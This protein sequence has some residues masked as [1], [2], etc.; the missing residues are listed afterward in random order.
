MK[1]FPV[2]F[3]LFSAGCFDARAPIDPEPEGRN[4]F[5]ICQKGC[6]HLE[7]LE[8]FDHFKSCEP[9]RNDCTFNCINSRYDDYPWEPVCWLKH[10]SC[11]NFFAL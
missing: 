9:Y 3:F 6:N 5:H 7:K 10:N 4:N 11:Q 1:L 2:L 8:G